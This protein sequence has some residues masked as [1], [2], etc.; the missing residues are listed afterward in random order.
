MTHTGASIPIV[1]LLLSVS[2]VGGEEAARQIP[3][4]LADCERLIREEPEQFE[5]FRCYWFVGRNHDRLP[6][7]AQRLESLLEP[8]RSN[9]HILLT[10]GAIA[11]DLGQERAEDLYREALERYVAVGDARGEIYCHISLAVIIRQKGLTRQASDHLQEALA[12][13]VEAGDEALEAQVRVNLGWQKYYE[14]E[15]GQAWELL[16]KAERLVFPEGS[17]FEQLGTLDGLAA[18]CWA[19]ERRSEALEYYRRMIELMQGT[20]PYRESDIRRNMAFV[21]RDLA[22]EGRL[23][24]EE[25][26]RLQREAL[27]AAIRTGNP[28]A[29]VGARLM[30]A[31]SLSGPEGL[32]Q[33]RIALA[34]ARKSGRLSEI[35]WALQLIAEKRQ[36]LDPEHPEPAFA[37]VEE[38]IELARS[39]GDPEVLAKALS[40]RARMRWIA[41]PRDRAIEDSFTALDAIERIRDLQPDGEVRARVFARF[42]RSHRNF[43]GTLLDDRDR[44]PAPDDI[45][46]AL[47]I[48]ERMRARSLLETLD[49]AGATAVLAPSGP[50]PDARSQVLDDIANLRGE[51]GRAELMPEERRPLRDRLSELEAREASLRLEIAEADPD[52]AVLRGVAVPSLDELKSGLDENQALIIFLI[53]EYRQR[54]QPATL[55]RSWAIVVSREQVRPV[56]LPDCRELRNRVRMYISLLNRK[57]DSERTAAKR[58]HRDLLDGALSALS[59][60]VSMLVVIPDGPL[61]RLP[62]GALIDPASGSFLAERYAVAIAPSAATWLRWKRSEGKVGRSSLL[63]FADPELPP[64]SVG[65]DAQGSLFRG[66]EPGLVPLPHARREA[67]M[68]HR[69]LGSDGQVLFGADASE[70]A[71]KQADPAAFRLL[72]FASHAVVNDEHPDRSAV[73]LAADRSEGGEDGLLRFREVVSLDLDGQLIL[74]AAC[75]GASGPLI[76]GEGVM[77]LANAFFQAGART[78][79]AGLRPVRDRETS[80]LVDRFGRHLAEGRSV[81]TAMALARRDLVKQ[82]L[83]PAAWASM[84]VLGDGDLVPFPDGR[85]RRWSWHPLV[86]AAVV[87]VALAILSGT[88]LLRKDRRRLS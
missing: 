36:R 13:S 72:H 10:L 66:Q 18:V 83:P 11:A 4:R 1:V 28:R 73:V 52:F 24:V 2:L 7:A 26:T 76:G 56:R 58:L 62:F 39:R 57:D 80:L 86:V 16:T 32:E 79:I 54:E 78:V 35:C 65:E 61:H 45:E 70:S 68:L 51:L 48:L 85:A 55:S 71:L 50:L 12:R 23:E 34:A 38:A 59:D 69:H 22:A 84:V 63:A 53:D 41:G 37:A 25:L 46:R 9:P 3:T 14:R 31:G 20:D 40:V 74:L 82:K 47:A 17:I 64:G 19:L 43:A 21:A 27:D 5:S 87:V 30:L 49:A 67:E 33:A 6:E 77:G 42:A 8:D 75:R 15:Y 60:R 44:A 81:A 88:L 29:E